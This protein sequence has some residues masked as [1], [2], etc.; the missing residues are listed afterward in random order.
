MSRHWHHDLLGCERVA[1]PASAHHIIGTQSF[2]L[3]ASFLYH[4][5]CDLATAASPSL[6]ISTFQLFKMLSITRSVVLFLVATTAVTAQQVGESCGVPGSEEFFKSDFKGP[7]L[8]SGPGC[9][10]GEEKDCYCTVDY[11]GSTNGWIWL[12]GTT[13]FG[14]AKD[15]TCPADIPVIEGSDD[16]PDCDTAVNPTGASEADAGCGA[17]PAFLVNRNGSCQYCNS[18]LSSLPPLYYM[19]QNTL[20]VNKTRAPFALVSICSCTV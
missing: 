20:T 15:K 8:V 14:P 18:N 9:T 10:L 3:F 12:C 4:H 7:N 1:L 19:L 6:F 5:Q 2:A 13:I 11:G 16:H 17:F